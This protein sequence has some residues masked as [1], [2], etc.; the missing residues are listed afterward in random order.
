MNI[1][2]AFPSKYV[3]VS[4]LRKGPITLTISHVTQEDMGEGD[5]KPVLYF[6]GAQKGMVVNR[7]NAMMISMLYGEETDS[8]TGKQI[9]LYIAPTT[10]MGKPTQGVRVAAPNGPAAPTIP[11]QAPVEQPQTLAQQEQG[12]DDEIPF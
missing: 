9:Q 10:Y 12:L 2:D 6:Q 8:W 1:Y 5:H 11:P 4:D 7:T 3:A